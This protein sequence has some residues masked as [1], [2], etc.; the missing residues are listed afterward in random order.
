MALS[1]EPGTSSAWHQQSKTSAA[2]QWQ[3]EHCRVSLCHYLPAL[4]C[5]GRQKKQSEWDRSY[6]AVRVKQRILLCTTQVHACSQF[7]LHLLL[8]LLNYELGREGEGGTKRLLLMMQ[9][10]HLT[11]TAD[12]LGELHPGRRLTQ[13]L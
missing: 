5:P 11:I 8:G 7:E 1:I 13:H 4:I 2:S 10:L 12:V 9:L 6:S 3:S